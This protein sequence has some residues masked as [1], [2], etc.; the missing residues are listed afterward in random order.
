MQFQGRAVSSP[1]T[2]TTCV[3]P[4]S[5]GSAAAQE[6]ANHLDNR[7]TYCSKHRVVTDA[8]T[9]SLLTVSVSPQTALRV[10]LVL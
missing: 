2:A 7:D 3:L 5:S 10:P 9:K 1:A 8:H 4:L 6:A